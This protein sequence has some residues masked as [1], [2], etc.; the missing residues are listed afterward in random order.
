MRIE[1]EDQIH[2]TEEKV[3]QKL[4][5]MDQSHPSKM[6]E[7]QQPSKM[8]PSQLLKGYSDTPREQ[9]TGHTWKLCINFKQMHPTTRVKNHKFEK[10]N[11]Y[12]KAK[13]LSK[14]LTLATNVAPKK[15]QDSLLGPAE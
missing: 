15:Q 14:S 1:L 6:D 12:S 11:D 7:Q 5:T 3:I 10:F 9:N 13:M 4:S 2:I 8:K